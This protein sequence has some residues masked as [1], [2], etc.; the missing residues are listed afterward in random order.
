MRTAGFG[1]VVALLGQSV[2]VAA[3]VAAFVVSAAAQFTQSLVGKPFG[4]AAAV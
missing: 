2:A 3:V 4:A 1:I